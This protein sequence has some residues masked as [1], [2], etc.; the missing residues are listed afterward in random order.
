[1]STSLYARLTRRFAPERI[2]VL[3]RRELLA[4]GT[5]A[6][7]LTL[8]SGPARAMS[9]AG[10]KPG[11]RVVVIGAGFAGLACAYELLSVGYDVTVID[12]R[13][14]AGGRVLSFNDSFSEF[15][16]GK[17]VEGGGE[18]VGSNHPMW[19]AYAAK[20][21][22]EFHEIAEPEDASY[23]VKLA[24]KMLSD[25]EANALYEEMDEACH[26][27]NDDAKAIDAD[28]PWKSPNAAALDKKNLQAWI[29]AL[30]VGELGKRGL[31]LQLSADNGVEAINQSYLGNLAMV[32]GGGIE[33][34][35][36]D[37]EIY[38]CKGGNDLVAKKLADAIT[39]DRIVL[40][41]PVTDVT[42][43]NGAMIV[44]CKDGRTLEC[45]DVVCAVA[46]TVWKRIN[47]KPGLPASL[48]PQMG[49]NVKYLSHV[50]KAFWADKKLAADALTDE[51]ISM[52][53]DGTDG[54]GEGEAC[55]TCFSGGKASDE[56]RALVP[57]ERKAAYA[58]AL[59][60]LY[61]GFND[62]FVDSRFMDWPGDQWVGASYSFPA[63][64]QVTAMGPTLRNGLG[65]LHFAGEHTCYKFV[66]Y[67]EG[68]LSSGAE[69]ARRMAQRDGLAP[70]QVKVEPVKVPE[71]GGSAKPVEKSVEK[72]QGEPSKEL[73]PTGPKTP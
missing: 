48:V 30:S 66:G 73:T 39:A 54:Q 41:L 49:S 60:A 31:T 27:M 11:K 64:G 15:V 40:G 5:A 42:S 9:M 56:A 18:L 45:D 69:L 63:P 13:S 4:M 59:E 2:N 58:K 28:E 67:M 62:N 16:K 33:K 37:S 12:A 29:D 34:F 51:F 35:W 46:P 24:G 19:M 65:N 70:R 36:T 47:F 14:R 6:A 38:R 72:P 43:K 55:L 25:D 17:N 44:T 53:W 1:M 20:F 23:P 7:A 21:G 8:L 10:R 61:P 68:A 26:S 71:Q 57:A 52:T 50:K 3:S 22:L 32:K